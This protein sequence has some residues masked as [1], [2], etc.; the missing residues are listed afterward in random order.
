MRV[1]TAAEIFEQAAAYE[2]ILTVR[3]TSVVVAPAEMVAW[4]M[5]TGAHV[6]YAALDER[7]HAEIAEA[8]RAAHRAIERARHPGKVDHGR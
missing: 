8:V 1:K 5:R 4:A 7:R 3:G 6:L 2:I